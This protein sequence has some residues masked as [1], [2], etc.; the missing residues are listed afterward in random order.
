MVAP[1]VTKPRPPRPEARAGGWWRILLATAA[2]I[3]LG[4]AGIGLDPINLNL[5]GW[6]WIVAADSPKP[7][8]VRVFEHDGEINAI[9]WSPDGAKIAAGGLLH[10]A[11]M[12]WDARTGALLRSLNREFGGVSAVAW[13][14]D[15][16]MVAAG[17]KFTEAARGHFAIHIWDGETGRVLQSL[18]GPSP[19]G[20]GDN[21]VFTGALSFSPDGALIAAGHRGSVSVHEATS[22]RLVSVCRGHIATGKAV[23][24]SPDGKQIATSGEYERSPLQI[25]D[26]HSGTKVRSM[27]GDPESPF[28]A[29]FRPDGKE[30]ATAAFGRS[31]VTVWNVL[32]GRPSRLLAGHAKPVYSVAY[33]ADGRLMASAAPGGGVIIWEAET[34]AQLLT[35]PN[36]RE[37]ADAIAFSPDGR[38]LAV[39]IGRQIRIWDLSTAPRPTRN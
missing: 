34:G 26:A 2:I 6:R 39:P 11:L 38:Y 36:P 24:F 25:F 37:L 13:G 9:A 16:K 5:D 35:L 19:L 7:R 29:A 32:D 17:R 10:N 28:A 31:V 14:R 18:L 3:G 22:G 27:T 23:A 1:C 21:D 30:I 33:S 15:G 8:L 4:W 20:R 12:I